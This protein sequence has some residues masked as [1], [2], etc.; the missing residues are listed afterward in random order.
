MT[1]ASRRP[2]FDSSRIREFAGED[3]FLRKNLE[4][5][6]QAG[7]RRAGERYCASRT[8]EGL[9]AQCA[10]QLYFMK[11]R[12]D[13]EMNIRVF[14]PDMAVHGYTSPYTVIET[15]IADRPFLLDT[16][17]LFF[18]E[19]G[20]TERECLH[21]I[22]DVC[23][24]G[25][26]E[27]IALNEDEKGRPCPIK[28]SVIHF[29]L[30]RIDEPDALARIEESLKERLRYA[31]VVVRDFGAMVER[32]NAAV[33]DLLLLAL[34]R[35]ERQAEADE[36]AA[37]LSW[38]SR[39]NFV[40]MG[41]YEAD[42]RFDGD[43][44]VTEPLD[45]SCLGLCSL[46]KN[47]ARLP[48]SAREWLKTDG[49]V[50]FGKDE[51]AS[52]VHR[53]GKIDL[54]LVRQL[55]S[56]G[57]LSQIRVLRGL[58]T[59][60]AITQ[61]GSDIPVL[62]ERLNV[63][64][65]REEAIPG[66]H[67]YKSIVSAFNSI[68][69]EYLFG[70]DLETIRQA[71]DLIVTN[72]NT[73]ESAVSIRIA[74]AGRS[75]L[76]LAVMPRQNYDE[77]LREE[78][79]DVLMRSLGATY[80]D[81]RLVLGEHSNVVLE[82]YLT[83]EKGFARTDIAALERRLTQLARPWIERFEAALASA[84]LSDDN[85]T[86]CRRYRD[87]FPDAYRLVTSTEEAVCDV[88]L[89]ER[90][91]QTGRLQFRVTREGENVQ[92]R[93]VKLKIY[94][95]RHI[96]LT[97]SLPVLHNFGLRAM[98]QSTTPVSIDGHTFYLDTFRIDG[99]EG[100]EDVDLIARAVD[101]ADG[102][103]MVLMRQCDD[104]PLNR[105]LLRADL[106]WREVDIIRAYVAYARQVE[107]TPLDAV[108]R[109]WLKHPECARLMIE[110]FAARF[111]PD[112]FEGELNDER[113]DAVRLARERYLR[114][115]KGVAGAAEDRILRLMLKLV[116][117]TLRTNAFQ[118]PRTPYLSFKLDSHFVHS[119]EKGI[120]PY[121]EIF[122]HHHNLEGIHLRG[123]PIARG[124]LRW[125]D[126]YDDYR[127]EILEL[128][129]T[130]MIKNTIIVPVG[131]KG[132]FILKQQYEG[133][134]EERAKAD[135]FY[136]VFIRGLLDLT[137]NKKNEEIVHPSRVVRWDGD[138]FYLVVAADKG[139][140]H[141]SDTANAIADAYHF[142]LGDAFASGGSK[143][144]DH[145]KEAITARGAWECVR[146]H[147]REL[148]MDPE[149]DPITVAA[150]GDMSGDVF[151]NGM[152][153]SRSMKLLAAFN[154]LHIFLDP[155]PDPA[156]SFEER[157]R[158]FLLPRS[159]WMDYDAAKIS[160]GGGVFRRDAKAIPLSPEVQGML[161]VC[162]DSL[163]G[164]EVIRHILTMK[165]DLLWNGG[166]GT[167][168]KASSEAPADV[169]DKVNAAVRVDAAAVKARVIGEGGNLGLTQLGRIEYARLG[170]R[171]N[172]DAIDNSGGVD[173]SDHEVNL[174]IL[175]NPLVAAGR[176]ESSE[177]DALLAEMTDDVARSVLAHNRS[178]S[179]MISLDEL[180]SRENVQ[181]FVRLLEDLEQSLGLDRARE[182]LPDS[183]ELEAR[184]E[185]GEGLY[186][187]ELAKLAALTKMRIKGWLLK[188][189][190]L[191][192]PFFDAM[193]LG[194]FPVAVRE[195]FRS[196]ILEH[197]LRSQIISTLMV[198]RI[199]DTAGATF[200]QETFEDTGHPAP[201]IAVA[202]L[203][204][205]EVLG[206]A[207]LKRRLL[208]PAAGIKSSALYS[209]ILRIE[210][211]LEVK[212]RRT[213]RRYKLDDP[214]TLI[215]KLRIDFQDLHLTLPEVLPE[216]A[217]VQL[218][219]DRAMLVREG[220][221]ERLA[222]D[223]AAFP[224][225]SSGSDIA[226]LRDESGLELPHAAWLYHRVGEETR[227]RAAFELAAAEGRAGRW[228][229]SALAVLRGRLID[230][231]YRMALSVARLGDADALE[232]HLA[233]YLSQRAPALDRVKEMERRLDADR[234]R[235]LGAV[236][237]LTEIIQEMA[238]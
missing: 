110:V 163:S 137:D 92:G 201:S 99:V 46:V 148:E 126:R 79:S 48:E 74:D 166:I 69:V 38:L 30:V 158:L 222:R 219:Q 44:L 104:D 165:V 67:L 151:G 144:Y 121:R 232:K 82:F 146:H 203:V 195:R 71:I 114:Y 229:K 47:Y 28:E 127:S 6:M 147:F 173:M 162:A 100:D 97:D 5:F 31:H 17:R 106:T 76:V 233:H 190:H 159:S 94:Q 228:E 9:A 134:E 198:N 90:L 18:S 169:P 14:N 185:R 216:R 54:L 98:D 193:L 3:D 68:P 150:I 199:I 53:A 73:K 34:Q 139:T 35:P 19:S 191:T 102:L 157:R 194:Y 109:I 176:L 136:Q 220:L 152:L 174:K 88:E 50:F 135:E 66:T 187:P 161:G 95:P 7:L 118:E 12:R 39:D 87:A 236:S 140:A 77:K 226:L 59:H 22:L 25:E 45:G 4:P 37:L 55:S 24:D 215:E 132:G 141:L 143:G 122:V 83:S 49:L 227:V 123:G 10:S 32:L 103:R 130:Q 96:F 64:L 20:L 237:V 210:S 60:R 70:S 200:F 86:L 156:G 149:T 13:D 221:P 33:K 65:T 62:R 128:M 113:R 209:A 225:L 234:A 15:C 108:R 84:R 178:Q 154:H 224:F 204:S 16:I 80:V 170:G 181:P 208:D 27:L 138:D 214:D 81:H 238:R 2:H 26:G 212:T 180:R 52:V 78:F 119:Q 107:Y 111:D 167:Y 105:L 58:L 211:A 43:R 40:F 91:R 179:L 36:A 213:L 11:K 205:E 63:I 1:P 23:R 184:A 61:N 188:D 120:G 153:L 230:L 8:L 206:G 177:R 145:K 21:P 202:R 186:R 112:L 175:L 223:V 89:L 142:W 192:G 231:Q 57:E 115:L 116:E 155:D 29:E 133:R 196:E 131:A 235:D 85:R 93:V 197:P 207:R 183:A 164:E 189:A 41:Y 75:A 129:T 172:T 51:Q 72:E 56:E 124:G 160:R 182:R 42:L 101:L 217:V 218:E 171:I 117:G 125:S 168:I